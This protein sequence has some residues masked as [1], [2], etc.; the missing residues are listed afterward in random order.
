MLIAT[1]HLVGHLVY[2]HVGHHVQ[3]HVNHFFWQPC[4]PPCPPPCLP[5]YPPPWRPPCQPPCR[6]P[7]CRLDAL[8]GLK[9]ADRM[10][11]REY[12][13]LTD[14]LT[15][16]RGGR[17]T[18]LDASFMRCSICFKHCPIVG[19][20]DACA[21]KNIL[22]WLVNQ[23]TYQSFSV[24][25][26]PVLKHVWLFWKLSLITINCIKQPS[27]WAGSRVDVNI[28]SLGRLRSKNQTNYCCFTSKSSKG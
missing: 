17:L 15:G 13:E 22:S 26:Y 7:Q 11:I 12:H 3:L 8:W 19:A 1:W 20:W 9:D 5:P 6:P 18:S 25:S 28:D 27:L 16:V 24:S 10:K 23:N 21:S 2:L 4:R 14:G